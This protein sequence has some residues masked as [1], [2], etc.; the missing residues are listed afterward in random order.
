MGN[1]AG[2]AI[3]PHGVTYHVGKV[4]AKLGAITSKAKIFAPMNTAA[5]SFRWKPGCTA[6]DFTYDL[7]IQPGLDAYLVIWGYFANR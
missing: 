6:A 7:P 4:S 1:A 5:K 3:C 2:V